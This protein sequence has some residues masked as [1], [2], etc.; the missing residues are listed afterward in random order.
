MHDSILPDSTLRVIKSRISGSG[1]RPS[2]DVI[3]IVLS[4]N[5][6]NRW[7][8][9]VLM[10][11]LPRPGVFKTRF[12]KQN[13][14]LCTVQKASKTVLLIIVVLMLI[15]NRHSIL[16]PIQIGSGCY[17]GCY[18]CWKIRDVLGLLI[19]SSACSVFS[20]SGLVF[21][22]LSFSSAS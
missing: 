21:S 2:A 11:T 14:R 6:S 22:V 17:P 10:R 19:H 5:R 12:Q 18:T 4:C 1:N 13:F 3:T 7:V 15:P 16:M 8:G 20:V 9:K